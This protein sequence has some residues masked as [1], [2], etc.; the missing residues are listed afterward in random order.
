MRMD[1]GVT[2][3]SSSSSIHSRHCSRVMI[4]GGVSWT[5]M[6]LPEA[7]M[8]VRGF[9]RQ[10]WT[11]MSGSRVFFWADMD[12]RVGGAGVFADD[13]AAVGLEAGGDEE[14]GALLERLDGVGGGVA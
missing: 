10:T 11:T 6:S 9:L 14:D 5:A 7:R 3:T 2:S 8:F 13:L 4:F 12:G 1:C